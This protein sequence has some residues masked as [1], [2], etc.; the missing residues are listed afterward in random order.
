MLI[1]LGLDFVFVCLFRFA[2]VCFCV[3]LNHV[4]S[5]LLT[6]VV[7]GLVSSVPS[8][9]VSKGTQNRNCNYGTYNVVMHSPSNGCLASLCFI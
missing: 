3:N 2:I 4:I 9:S 8:Y 6:F 5:V 1:D 7:L